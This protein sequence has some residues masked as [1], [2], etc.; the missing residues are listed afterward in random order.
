[1]IEP[2]RRIVVL[3]R[4]RQSFVAWHVHRPSNLAEDRVAKFAVGRRRLLGI[5]LDHFPALG[6]GCHHPTIDLD[7]I[8][9][10]NVVYSVRG[11]VKCVR[12]RL[13]DRREVG[14][15]FRSGNNCQG[16]ASQHGEQWQGGCKLWDATHL[17]RSLGTE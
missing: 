2:T 12:L 7:E 13:E 11:R 4:V 14:G 6:Q 9:G 8:K 1:M 16:V 3:R 15:I 5:E 17:T 10:V